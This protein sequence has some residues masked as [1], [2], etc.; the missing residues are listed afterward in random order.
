MA[1]GGG[2]GGN[3][4]ALD[5]GICDCG[6]GELATGESTGRIDGDLADTSSAGTDGN[7]LSF[8]GTGC[9][10]G[11]EA[12]DE[13]RLDGFPGCGRDCEVSRCLEDIDTFDV[14]RECV[15]VGRSG[16][17]PN[18]RCAGALR[19][20]TCRN[21]ETLLVDVGLGLTAGEVDVDEPAV[22]S[23]VATALPFDKVVSGV[24]GDV[25]T[26]MGRIGGVC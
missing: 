13:T 16:E 21:V 26:G 19:R 1:F 6:G 23:G 12:A 18:C 22:G 25:G 9:K 14:V 17:E 5:G 8:E 10:S 24:A 4:E 2:T 20:G 3:G 11:V 7:A 15:S